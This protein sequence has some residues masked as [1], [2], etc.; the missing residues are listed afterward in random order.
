MVDAAGGWFAVAVR[1]VALSATI[2]ALGAW[3][4][5]RLVVPRL[6]GAPDP[7]H[8]ERLRRL[9]D[10]AVAWCLGILLL[11]CVV[12]LALGAQETLAAGVAAG[13]SSRVFTW[14][15]ALLL[16]GAGAVIAFVAL[17]ARRSTSAWP[18]YAEGTLAV[19]A[20]TP[21]F[22][23][24]AGSATEWR[25]VAVAVDVVHLLA[26]AG[27]IGALALV[28]LAAGVVRRE[29]HGP[30]SIAALIAAFHPVA[31]VAAPAV[32]ATGLLTAWLRM[33]VPEG[34]A[35]PTYSGLFVAKLLL[36]GVTGYIGAGHSRLATKRLATV[37]A[38][39][40]WRSLLLECG[41]AAAVLLVTAV[42]VGTSPI[43]A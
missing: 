33:G 10:Q 6:A 12:R 11:S 17:L 22:L 36:V 26:A 24:N 1:Y 4:V 38:D 25:A 5:R 15:L 27:W 31:V 13:G 2:G 42:L 37:P 19:V 21:P 18:W 43:A 7:A 23:A 14:R 40:T 32:V 20:V 30:A 34:I 29:P 16:Q 3:V 8:A 39:A 28:T 35:S 9:A 41:F